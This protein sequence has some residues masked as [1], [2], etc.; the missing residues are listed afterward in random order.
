MKFMYASNEG[1]SSL[2]N[3]TLYDLLSSKYANELLGSYVTCIYTL[4]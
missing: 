2:F 4:I 3:S 1:F